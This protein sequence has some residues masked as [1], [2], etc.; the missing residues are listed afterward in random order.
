M[1]ARELFAVIVRAIG[2]GL[3]VL[4]LVALG[5]RLIDH[6]LMPE[7]VQGSGEVAMSVGMAF[8]SAF[9]LCLILGTKQIVRLIYGPQP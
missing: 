6:F 2:F 7:Y 1:T 4:G 3:L 5:I 9:G 8:I